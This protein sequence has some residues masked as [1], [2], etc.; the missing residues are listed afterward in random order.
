MRKR[1]LCRVDPELAREKENQATLRFGI[2][3]RN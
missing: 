3:C 1:S 2:D